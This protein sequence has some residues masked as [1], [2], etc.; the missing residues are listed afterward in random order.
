[1]QKFSVFVF[2]AALMAFGF[3]EH[4]VS[5]ETTPAPITATTPAPTPEPTPG[6]GWGEGCDD[7]RPSV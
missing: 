2:V 7:K 6:W 4:A 1:M 3:A 5:A